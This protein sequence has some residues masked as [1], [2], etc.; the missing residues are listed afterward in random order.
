V[1]PIVAVELSASDTS[2]ELQRSLLEACSAGLRRARCVPATR[3]DDKPAAVAMVTWTDAANARVEVGVEQAEGAGWRVREL[4]FAA[5][6]PPAERWRAAGF[7]IA[8]LVG[9][10]AFA[11][12]PVE[13]PPAPVLDEPRPFLAL[14]LKALTGTGAED[15][16]RFGGEL[17]ALL[18]L[19][20]SAWFGSVAV[21]YALAPEPVPGVDLRWLDLA[22]G[23]GLRSAL[24]ADLSGRARLELLLENVAASAERGGASASQNAWVPGLRLGGDVIWPALGQWGLVASLDVFWLDGS[25]PVTVAAERV[26]ESAAAGVT[27]GLGLEGRL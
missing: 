5:E 16:W 24:W 19:P 25:T 10:K 21:R 8:L 14:D 12:E 13:P 17:G 1:L 9:E 20:A 3:S 11:D 4:S 15:G 22:L 18:G 23:G 26:T 6:D 2:P 27:L 7:T